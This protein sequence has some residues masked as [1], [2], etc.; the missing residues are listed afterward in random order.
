[1]LFAF[2]LEAFEELRISGKCD[3]RT[4]IAVIRSRRCRGLSR[5][6]PLPPAPMAED[7]FVRAEPGA[8]C[9]C[10]LFKSSAVGDQLIVGVPVVVLT[11]HQETTVRANTIRKRIEGLVQRRA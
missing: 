11:V 10:H 9:D 5:P 7:D 4:L 3:V 1:M 8:W 6:P 2:A